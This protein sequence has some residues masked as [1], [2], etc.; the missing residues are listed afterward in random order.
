MARKKKVVPVE[1]TPLTVELPQTVVIPELDLLKLTRAEAE[2]RAAKAELVNLRT[3]REF[4]L[5]K[6]DPKGILRQMD[7][8]IG[9]ESAKLREF[10]A[11]YEGHRDNI[12]KK[13]NIDM[14]K[15]S[16]DDKTG[17]VHDVSELTTPPEENKA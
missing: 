14:K 8:R 5:Q 6:I 7:A 10:Q 16:Y 15:C 4:Y 3:G 13:L 1:P 17:V 12:G 9:D 2:I 11:E